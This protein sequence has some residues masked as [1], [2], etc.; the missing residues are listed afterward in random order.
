MKKIG[1]YGGTFSPP[2]MGHIRA[3]ELFIKSRGL[4][5]LHII[6]TYQP[7]HKIE[8]EGA[9]PEDRLSMC[10][11]AFGHI[12]G[13]TV[14]DREIL[15]GGK[16]YSV[17]TLREYAEMGIRPEMLVGTDMLLTLEAWYAF[18]EILSLATVV[19]MRRERDKQKGEALSIIAE[20]LTR[21]YGA[22][23]IF[24]YGDVTEVSSSELRATLHENEKRSTLL[25]PDIY[26]YIVSRNLY[27]I[28]HK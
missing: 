23:I 1:I 21:K 14:S 4:D 20:R 2:H 8:D 11:L 26:D 3:A 13:V 27:G 5:E 25:P 10:K 15:R 16:S 7:P 28:S 18:E 24:L 9:T 22:S 17:L 6:P 12:D 19:C